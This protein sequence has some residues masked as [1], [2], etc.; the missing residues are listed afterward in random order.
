MRKD[1]A[2][3]KL[4]SDIAAGGP[5]NCGG[6]ILIA[7]Y[8]RTKVLPDGYGYYY[9]ERDALIWKKNFG[10]IIW[11]EGISGRRLPDYSYL[12]GAYKT[13]SL[14]GT[15]NIYIQTV[16][17]IKQLGVTGGNMGQGK[18]IHIMTNSGEKVLYDSA[19][20]FVTGQQCCLSIGTEKR[21]LALMDIR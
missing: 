8:D 20:P 4:L 10:Y 13:N 6:Q 21:Y 12:I 19:T 16:H 14:I 17:G 18:H 5:I 7:T 11:Q 3:Y 9:T 15:A 1:V 2:K